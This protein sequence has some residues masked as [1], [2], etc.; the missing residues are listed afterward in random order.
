[1]IHDAEVTSQGI[2]TE[3]VI[4]QISWCYCTALIINAYCTS[5]FTAQT[6][7]IL[8]I[9]PSLYVARALHRMLEWKNHQVPWPCHKAP[10][11]ELL[12]HIIKRIN[13]ASGIYQMFFM[14]G[15]VIIL[16]K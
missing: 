16:Q 4:P 15:D 7:F 12:T 9:F 6:L 11:S 5:Q 10:T 8:H 14:L 2:N 1:M 13:E 3:K